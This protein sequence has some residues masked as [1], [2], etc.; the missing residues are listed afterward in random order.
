[1][2]NK[3]LIIVY[4][5]PGKGK[6]TASLGQVLRGLGQGFR[7]CVIQFIKGKWPTGEA[8]FFAAFK[9]KAEFH[10]MGT[11]FTW[12]GDR[13][14]IRDA[15]K[16]AWLFA[17]EKIMSAAYDMVVLDELTYLVTYDL[18]PEQE[19]IDVLWNK[20]PALHVVISGRNASQKLIELADI[21]SDIHA[22]KHPCADG[23]AAQKGIEF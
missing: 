23:L 16:K 7:V 19:I 4:T 13:E 10:T 6:T 20:P 2:E 1:M 14:E 11:G 9:E 3:G 12:E 8:K 18:V 5:G 22:V 21:V 15:A 17:A